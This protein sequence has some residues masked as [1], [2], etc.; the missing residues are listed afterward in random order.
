MFQYLL[1]ST[2]VVQ[3]SL[4]SLH[5]YGRF[6][7][8][9]WGAWKPGSRAHLKKSLFFYFFLAYSNLVYLLLANKSFCFFFCSFET[10]KGC[11]TG[12]E[13]CCKPIVFSNKQFSLKDNP[14]S[15]FCKKC[16]I[17]PMVTLILL[18]EAITFLIKLKVKTNFIT[19]EQP[20]SN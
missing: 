20:L 9:E 6:K 19:I 16:L 1:L 10:L 8:S 11:S 2:H 4:L 7:F 17:F 18:L 14:F 15:D 5:S 12:F 3:K 13:A